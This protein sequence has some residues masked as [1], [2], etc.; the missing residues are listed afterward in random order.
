MVRKAR[1][2]VK[3]Q[4]YLH[5]RHS[6]PRNLLRLRRERPDTVCMLKVGLTG[7]LAS[8]KSTVL[9]L[10]A[11]RGA[12]TLRADHVAHQLMAPGAPLYD[13]IVAA[14]GRGI[15]AP[16]GSIDRPRLASAAFPR[17]IAELNAIVHPAV[18]AFENEWMRRAGEE[19]PSA[20]AICEAAL[21]IEAG[22]ADRFDRLIVVTCPEEKR[23]ERFA[24]RSGLPLEKARAEVSRRMKAQ[25]PEKKKADFADFLIDN[26]GTADELRT[27]VDYIWNQLTAAARQ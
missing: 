26:S 14:F 22:G 7:G 1:R 24:V 19:D 16:D 17:R 4:G 5:E 27:L 18:M 21:L 8:G 11:A 10:F 20:V 23:A 15:L 6:S 9:E 12:R 2:K 25:M 13:P 3:P